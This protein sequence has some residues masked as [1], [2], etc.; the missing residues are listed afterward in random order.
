M[1]ESR[2]MRFILFLRSMITAGIFTVIVGPLCIATAAIDRTGGK[3]YAL[4]RL[5]CRLLLVSN[6]VK[7][8]IKGLENL[9]KMKSY[10]FISNHQSHLDILAAATAIKNPIKFVYK[11][12]LVKIPVFGQALRLAKMIPIE[13]GD[14]QK[15]IDSINKS[16]REL[17]NGIGAFFFGEGTRTRD[18]LIQPFKKG[19]I[20]FSIRAKLPIVPVTIINGFNLLPKGSLHIKSGT[21][22]IIIDKAIS[23]SEYCAEN[24]DLLLDKVRSIIAENLKEQNLELS[25]N[26]INC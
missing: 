22:K 25:E 15:A 3:I 20:M 23:T 14:T 21:M 11:R 16:A 13:R 18:G 17:K 10:V 12:S 7:V 4:G 6:G 5:W 8:C 9:E 24:A 19:G 2:I 1:K 26:R